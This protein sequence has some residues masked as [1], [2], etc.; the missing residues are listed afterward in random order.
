MTI[1]RAVDY[2]VTV[3]AG[4]VIGHWI[5]EDDHAF[6]I[7]HYVPPKDID[8]GQASEAE[9]GQAPHRGYALSQ[10]VETE[11]GQPVARWH[12]YGTGQAAGPETGQAIGR[13]QSRGI[14]QA[15]AV[16][17][18]QA[19]GSKHL[20]GISQALEPEAGQAITHSYAYDVDQATGSDT[21]SAGTVL[22]STDVDQGEDTEIAQAISAKMTGLVIETDVLD[23][24]EEDMAQLPI[25]LKAYAIETARKAT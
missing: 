13:R 15:S 25:R 10:A 22:R 8:V 12:R 11:A 7:I 4:Q 21:A 14:D 24:F 2:A 6:P 5:S 1:N 23:S 18:G 20:R 9:I 19:T 3:E 17:I 16:E